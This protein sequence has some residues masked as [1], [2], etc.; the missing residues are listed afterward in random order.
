[1]PLNNQHPTNTHHTHY[2]F[3]VTDY[4]N[5]NII[6]FIDKLIKYQKNEYLLNIILIQ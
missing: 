6:Q 5:N 4:N 3:P 2:G 1:M